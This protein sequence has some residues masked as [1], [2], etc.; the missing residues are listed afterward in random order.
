VASRC[1]RLI[2]ASRGVTLRLFATRF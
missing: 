2:R 1:S